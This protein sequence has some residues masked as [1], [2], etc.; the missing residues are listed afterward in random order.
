MSLLLCSLL[1]ISKLYLITCEASKK[2][3]KIRNFDL[4]NSP[5]S[6]EQYLCAATSSYLYSVFCQPRTN[7]SRQHDSGL[8]VGCFTNSPEKIRETNAKNSCIWEISHVTHIHASPRTRM[9]L[10]VSSSCRHTRHRRAR[11]DLIEGL[12]QHQT[13]ARFISLSKRLRAWVHEY[14]P[15]FSCSSTA[16]YFFVIGDDKGGLTY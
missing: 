1:R 10:S 13:L 4:F 3:K 11:S 14:K 6:T 9:P 8:K 15:A 12:S 5:I 7:E 16:S 2:V